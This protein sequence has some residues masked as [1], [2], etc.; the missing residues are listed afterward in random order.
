MPL[1]NRHILD[2]ILFCIGFY[3]GTVS[4]AVIG[5]CNMSPSLYISCSQMIFKQIFYDNFRSA[6]SKPTDCQMAELVRFMEEHQHLAIGMLSGEDG[7]LSK[8][9]LLAE[10]S[11]TLN[12]MGIHKTGDEWLKVN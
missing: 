1:K 7:K 12:S 8:I 4:Y 9:E 10:L 6:P 11:N 5:A 3:V 2:G